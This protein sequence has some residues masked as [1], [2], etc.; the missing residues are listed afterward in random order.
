MPSTFLDCCHLAKPRTGFIAQP[1]PDIWWRSMKW[2]IYFNC[3]KK[4]GW[5]PAQA[6]FIEE[7]KASRVSLEASVK[8]WIPV[9]EPVWAHKASA[10]SFTSTNP[11]KPEQL[12]NRRVC[13]LMMIRPVWRSHQPSKCQI[14]NV[15]DWCNQDHLAA[16]C[17]ANHTH[18]L[19]CCLSVECRSYHGDQRFNLLS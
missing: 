4:C 18:Y 1:W 14:P 19:I 13:I 5:S 9:D 8:Q 7:R 12:E 2:H 3:Q 11:L 16:N 6:A 17:A 10:R 15:R